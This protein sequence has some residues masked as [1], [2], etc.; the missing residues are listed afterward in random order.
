M[1]SIYPAQYE[2]PTVKFADDMYDNQQIMRTGDKFIW[3]NRTYTLYGWGGGTAGAKYDT[4]QVWNSKN[5]RTLI[6]I[7][8][9]Q[10]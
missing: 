9:K 4:F 6:K 5:K 10:A 2:I 3:R 1:D 7:P 8:N